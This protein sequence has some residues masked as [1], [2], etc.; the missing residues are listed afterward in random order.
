MSCHHD[1]RD[2]VEF[3][4]YLHLT[5]ALLC[6]IGRWWCNVSDADLEQ[7]QRLRSDLRPKTGLNHMTDRN[8]GMLRQFDDRALALRALL[9]PEAVIVEYHHRQGFNNIEACRIQR[10]TMVA[11]QLATA[12]RPKNLVGLRIGKHLLERDGRFHIHIPASEVKNDV[13]LEF[14]LPDRTAKILR[15]Y[16]TKVRPLLVTSD[17][18]YVWPGRRNGKPMTTGY[19]GGL[20]G[21]FMEVEVGVRVT[22][23]RFR[24]LAGYLYLLDNP[25]GYEVVRLLLGHK[26]I[27]TTMTFYASL[28]AKEGFKRYDAAIERRLRELKNLN[29]SDDDGGACA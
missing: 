9:L 21:N 17:T 10:A 15:F 1:D 28:E 19:V 27:K 2:P 8:R 23:H 22:G 16:L 4:Q 29:D 11:V 3:T 13:E 18:D 26:S 6:T 7:L 20:I 25:N 12:L 24:H 14:V 5:A